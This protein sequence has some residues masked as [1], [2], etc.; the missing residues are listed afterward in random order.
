MKNEF[1]AKSSF[2]AGDRV[3]VRGRGTGFVTTAPGSNGFTTVELDDGQ[4]YGA[5][6]NELVQLEAEPF[7]YSSSG[8]ITIMF[9]TSILEWF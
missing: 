6:R 8:R 7:V 9:G 4:S 2:D 1:K 3:V 5:Y